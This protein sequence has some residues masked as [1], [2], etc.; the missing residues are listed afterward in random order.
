MVER[1]SAALRAACLQG[2]LE[3]WLAPQ[4]TCTRIDAA[5][6]AVMPGLGAEASTSFVQTT[7]TWM[8]RTGPAVTVGIWS[9]DLE[10]TARIELASSRW[11]REALPLS[12]V[13]MVG[14]A[15][16]RTCTAQRRRVTAGWVF[17][18]PTHPR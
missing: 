5:L 1:R 10:R 2:M 17:P 8:G 11:R 18:F 14:V 4:I 16:I 9:V 15:R 3:P 13:R 7:K 6:C 12:Y